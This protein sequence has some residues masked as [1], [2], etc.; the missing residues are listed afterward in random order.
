M[1]KMWSKQANQSKKSLFESSG[2]SKNRSISKGSDFSLSKERTNKDMNETHK[3]EKKLE[4]EALHQCFE[5]FIKQEENL[6]GVL[7]TKTLN[8]KNIEFKDKVAFWRETQDLRE[9]KNE[10]LRT[11]EQ[12][13][14]NILTKYAEELTLDKDLVEKCKTDY[15]E[16]ME[17]RKKNMQDEHILNDFLLTIPE[18][19]ILEL[20]DMR[21]GV[22]KYRQN[23]FTHNAMLTEFVDKVCRE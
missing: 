14:C 15:F 17:N 5:E 6:S 13:V 23:F 20:R 2:M 7:N 10:K 21:K 11:K 16:L 18:T 4:M 8:L 22:D 3:D 12:Q 19:K 1:M 9:H